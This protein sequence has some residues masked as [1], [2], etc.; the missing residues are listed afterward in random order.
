[1]PAQGQQAALEHGRPPSGNKL[2]NPGALATLWVSQGHKDGQSAV[3][4]RRSWVVHFCEGLRLING[5]A[6][7]QI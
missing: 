4:W 5:A 7:G 3:P 1:M 6:Q 2:P